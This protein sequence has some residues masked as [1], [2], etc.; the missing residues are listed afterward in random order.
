MHILNTYACSA[1]QLISVI[2][3]ADAGAHT[4][5]ASRARWLLLPLQLC[6]GAA[7][8]VGRQIERANA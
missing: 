6:T 8:L 3:A 4:T 1:D 7:V 5:R 2:E